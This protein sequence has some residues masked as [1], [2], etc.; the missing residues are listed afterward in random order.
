[1]SRE[2]SRHLL[3]V[4]LRTLA[5]YLCYFPVV[6]LAGHFFLEEQTVKLAVLLM[7][8]SLAGILIGAIT[9]KVY[10]EVLVALVL[11]GVGT[12]ALFGVIP[13]AL[14]AFGL[15]YAMIHLGMRSAQNNPEDVLS[16]RVLALG[17]ATFLLVPIFYRLDP[18]LQEKAFGHLAIG[19]AAIA[20]AF[21]LLNRMQLALA[22]LQDRAGPGGVAPDIRVKNTLYVVALLAAVLITANIDAISRGLGALWD[23]FIAWLNQIS[24][25]SGERA[26]IPVQPEMPMIP[27]E[28]EPEKQ[29]PF[30]AWLQDLIVY[31][32][33]GVIIVALLGAIGYLMV[34]QLIP[35]LRRVVGGL[36]RERE[37]KVDYKDETERLERPDLRALISRTVSRMRPR[38]VVLPDDPRER[39]RM[40]YRLM[41]E[42]AAKDGLPADPALTPME[43]AQELEAREWR[44]KP[45]G[46]L[47][48]LYNPVRY[49]EKNVD[50]KD[51]AELEQAWD[52]GEKGKR[53]S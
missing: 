46:L 31:V 14:I 53:R 42:A 10:A 40:R 48:R 17:L 45:A 18:F 24:R 20:T 51:L 38:Q 34:T 9:M 22:N 15:L 43:T 12:F 4:A 8:G 32:I 50:P 5:M 11:S 1:M 6:L 16:S 7:G 28:V 13:R 26:D 23:R 21:F 52:S 36:N 39:V 37:R 47:V 27:I 49:G 41:L 33:S 3:I 35:F 30:W 2:Q 19:V 25:S 29:S 44:K